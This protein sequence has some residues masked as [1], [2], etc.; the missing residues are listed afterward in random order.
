MS[1]EKKVWIIVVVSVALF[2]F[3]LYNVYKPDTLPMSFI[4]GDVRE[5]TPGVLVGPYPTEREIKRL[6]R[7]G[8]V[9]FVNLMD[10][11]NPLEK[12]L[13]KA[14]TKAAGKYGLQ[15]VNFPMGIIKLNGK[16]NKATVAKAVEKARQLAETT[17]VQESIYIHCYLGRHRVG[18]F[19]EAYLAAYGNTTGESEP[20]TIV[21]TNRAAQPKNP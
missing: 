8:V 9:G 19:A 14:E 5:I 11:S 4:R 10:A 2:A 6:K 18:V 15:V 7:I 1:T 16:A 13:F 20:A 12:D 17:G 21:P 3:G